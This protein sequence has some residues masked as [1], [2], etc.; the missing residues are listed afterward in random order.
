MANRIDRSRFRLENLPVR[1]VP[2]KDGMKHGLLR[3]VKE[4]ICEDGEM[5]PVDA[6][7]V[8]IEW[9]AMEFV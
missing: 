9:F 7:F 6:Y 1:F 2:L 3:V 4:M 8:K 5:I